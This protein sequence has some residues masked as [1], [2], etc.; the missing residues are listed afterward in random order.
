MCVLAQLAC[1]SHTELEQIGEYASS[2][3][4]PNACFIPANPGNPD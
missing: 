1:I 4:F 3:V 2:F